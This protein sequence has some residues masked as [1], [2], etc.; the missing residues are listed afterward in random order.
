MKVVCLCLT[1]VNRRG[2]LE[3]AIKCFLAQH[4][5]DLELLIVDDGSATD[6]ANPEHRIRVI[7]LI[8]V[9][10]A[11]R[12]FGVE[13]ARDA[14]VIVHWDDDDFSAA[15]RVSF[16]VQ[17]LVESGKAVHGFH[18]MQFTD[19]VHRWLYTSSPMYALGTSL[20]Y[21]R[22]WAIAH[23]FEPIQ[24]GQ[25]EQFG[26]LAI[27]AGQITT[28]DAGE[29]MYATNHANNTSPRNIDLNSASWS[30]V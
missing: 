18:S 28:C 22:W 24:C 16:Q 2:W 25:D 12:N 26:D 30:V 14:D 21:R 23:P 15:G 19:G 11:K 3:M 27:R 7:S 13:C 17:Q 5:P 1:T 29:L 10:G 9:V 6:L 8:D 20:C 4:Y